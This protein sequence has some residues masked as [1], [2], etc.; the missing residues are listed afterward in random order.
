MSIII[1]PSRYDKLDLL[2]EE[3]KLVRTLLQYKSDDKIHALLNIY[4]FDV[5]NEK[6]SRVHAIIN[7]NK[8]AIVHVMEQM[9]DPRMLEDSIENFKFIVQ[10]NVK[11]LYTKLSIH[12]G[13]RV[14][15]GENDALKFGISY[16]FF[17]PNISKKINNGLIITKAD[18]SSS[19][20]VSIF[21][22]DTL[23]DKIICNTITPYPKESIDLNEGDVNHIMQMISPEYII[24]IKSD[25]NTECKE[26]TKIVTPNLSDLD[27]DVSQN[28]IYTRSLRLSGEQIDMVNSIRRGNQLIL[29]SAG[30]GKSV[31]LIS[32]M[33]KIASM[34]PNKEFVLLCYN[35]N[36]A[37]MYNWK[38]AV[39]GFK[40]RNVKA[41]T[42]HKFL[43]YIMEKN[44]LPCDNK[45]PED[46]YPLA[47]QY[48]AEDKIKSRY[49][50]IFIDE[51]QIFKPEWYKFCFNMLENR[52]DQNEYFLTICGDLSQN[53][54][55]EVKQGSAPW[56]GH[57][58]L[59]NYR[60]RTTHLKLNYRNSIQVNE[61][62][63]DFTNY[64]KIY[65]EKFDIELE[66][67]DDVFID[68]NAIR[69]GPVP[70]LI[71]S[72]R[73]NCK[74]A[75]VDEV[76]QLIK[77][78]LQPSDIAI[79]F[80][81]RFY[82]SKNYYIH[83]WIENELESNNIP[84]SNLITKGNNL[85]SDYSNYKG[86]VLSTI[87]S[88]LGLDF[89]AVILTGLM[90]LG[91]YNRSKHLPNVN[92][93]N[94]SIKNDFVEGINKIYTGCTRARSNLSIVLEETE[95]ESIYS[96]IIIDSL[97]SRGA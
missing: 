4:P 72:D 27:Y 46:L 24:P 22:K 59:P 79:L 74:S 15:D 50:G 13:L 52:I 34:H 8:L 19:N 67:K 75:I 93:I 36:L 49:Y 68:S 31:I 42:F 18:L 60:G 14:S 76:N 53:I 16:I 73:F 97:N 2:A 5:K 89:E 29:A 70:R 20:L 82:R 33:F 83:S 7:K 96:K 17:A 62:I 84:F 35:R 80:P 94:S 38:I 77:S 51:I 25:I 41:M 58:S 3:R 44:G 71:M 61:F 63:R 45:K 9:N 78:G 10:S 37:S 64:A 1:Y 12:K 6:T 92:D 95:R 28:E 56:Q 40:E 23:M 30:S 85:G 91:E 54:R 32:K 90:P 81:Q 21:T 57:E 69:H 65:F 86:V 43:K 55:N 88:A 11:K 47:V 66:E 26:I 48:F 39:S 87:E